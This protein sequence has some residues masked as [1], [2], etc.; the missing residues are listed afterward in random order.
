VL[1]E[2]KVEECRAAFYAADTSGDGLL[3]AGNSR[4]FGRVTGCS[5]RD[6]SGAARVGNSSYLLASC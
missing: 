2:G 6:L 3:G 5:C 1:L 4:A